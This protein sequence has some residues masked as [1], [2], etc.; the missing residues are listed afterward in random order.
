MSIDIVKKVLRGLVLSIPSPFG[1][2][3][4]KLRNDYHQLEGGAIPF[5]DFGFR[6]EL[7]FLYSMHDCIRVSSID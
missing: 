4:S 1:V 7:D 5:A 2:P 3:L 6:N